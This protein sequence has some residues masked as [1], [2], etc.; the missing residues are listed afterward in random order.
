MKKV[1]Y[2][3]ALGRAYARSGMEAGADIL[4]LVTS[5]NS[6]SDSLGWKAS[7]VARYER[8]RIFTPDEGAIL[9]PE[10]APTG[11]FARGL[12]AMKERLDFGGI[13]RGYAAKLRDYGPELE[14]ADLIHAWDAATVLA[15]TKR[16][17]TGQKRK[18]LLFTPEAGFCG[19]RPPWADA[20]RRAALAAADSLVLPGAWACAAITDEYGFKGRCYTL[21]RGVE[22]IKHLRTGRVRAELGLKETDIL[23]CSVG[24]LSPES[25]F[26]SLVEAMRLAVKERP[27]GLYCAIAGTGPD[28]AALR[29]GIEAAGLCARVKLLGFRSDAGELLADAEIFAAPALKTMSDQGVIEAM[30]AGLAIVLSDAGGNPEALCWGQAGVLVRAGDPAALSSAILKIAGSP[31]ELVYLSARARTF[32]LKTHSLEALSSGAARVYIKALEEFKK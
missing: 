11:L 1:I 19:P 20:Q 27:Y 29:S 4:R 16:G 5:L 30:R 14:Q 9:R 24:R 10:L 6:A 23:I 7:A 25:G 22:D 13:V 26:M 8:L 12:K 28:E 18:P 3:T 21:P 2:L 15:F 17:L 31:K 32:Y